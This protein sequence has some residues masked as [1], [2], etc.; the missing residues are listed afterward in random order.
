MY[1]TVYIVLFLLLANF[2]F[3]VIYLIWGLT[4]RSKFKTVVRAPKAPDI[5]GD[6]INDEEYRFVSEDDVPDLLDLTEEDEPEEEE[7]KKDRRRYVM[8][9]ICFLLFPIASELTMGCAVLFHK[10]FFRKEV[11]LSAV[12]FDKNQKRPKHRGDDERERNLVPLEEALA[13]TDSKNLRN[14]MLNILKGDVSESLHVIM[15]ALNSED[16]ETAHYAAAVLSSELND[17]RANVSTTYAMIEQNLEELEQKK[18]KEEFS[19]EDY[20]EQEEKWLNYAS[21]LIKYIYAFLKQEIFTDMEEVSYAAV[22]ADTAEIIYERRK[23]MLF[24]IHYEW[25]CEC[26]LRTEQLDRCEIWANRSA[27]AYPD[28]LSAFTGRLRLYFKTG[29]Q[30][31]FRQVMEDLQNSDVVIDRDTLELIRAFR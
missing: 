6:E 25:I 29:E 13:V 19:A 11:D 22:M 31:K 16:T 26:L 1:D 10:L 23:E 27:L 30:E 8:L 2:I 17:F 4:F 3:S 28:T 21:A 9:F 18:E 24:S 14:L 5:A 20:S 15:Q 12:V 7:K